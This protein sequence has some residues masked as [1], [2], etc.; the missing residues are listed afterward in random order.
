MLLFFSCNFLLQLLYNFHQ[1][2]QARQLG[3]TP[4]AKLFIKSTFSVGLRYILPPLVVG[5]WKM[6]PTI[7]IQ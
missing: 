2:S 6:I 7:C 1:E 5:E 4:L 3:G